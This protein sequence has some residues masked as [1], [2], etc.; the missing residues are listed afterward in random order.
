M[1]WQHCY[2]VNNFNQ[3]KNHT[4]LS[5]SFTYSTSKYKN[6]VNS[7]FLQFANIWT[8]LCGFFFKPEG[9]TNI[10]QI[11]NIHDIT[12]GHIH[13]RENGNI[14]KCMIFVTFTLDTRHLDDKRTASVLDQLLWDDLYPC[15]ALTRN[16]LTSHCAAALHEESIR[17]VDKTGSNGP[18][19]GFLW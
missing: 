16:A 14:S 2:Y 11:T 4:T 13:I 6:H 15:S 3:I 9:N 8:W 19:P 10:I 7:V 12:S 5:N 17:A 1:E 18:G